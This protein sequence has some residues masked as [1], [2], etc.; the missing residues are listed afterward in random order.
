[1]RWVEKLKK[2]ET[3]FGYKNLKN[4]RVGIHTLRFLNSR[5]LSIKRGIR[6][7]Q[8]GHYRQTNVIESMRKGLFTRDI[9]GLHSVFGHMSH[10]GY[11]KSPENSTNFNSLA[12]PKKSQQLLVF[13]TISFEAYAHP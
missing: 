6:K 2:N 13:G 5:R 4:V 11:P 9:F 10:F 3:R 12:P 1:M 8:N 7:L